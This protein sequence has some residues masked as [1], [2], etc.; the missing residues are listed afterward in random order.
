M[1]VIRGMAPATREW[2]LMV[3]LV[4]PWVE[5]RSGFQFELGSRLTLDGS[6]NVTA[7]RFDEGVDHERCDKSREDGF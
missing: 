4:F 7:A 6:R 3:I 1:N 2:D 5:L